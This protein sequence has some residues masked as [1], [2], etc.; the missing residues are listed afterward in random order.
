MITFATAGKSNS[1]GNRK[2]PHDLPD[3]LA[4]FGLNGFEVQC[5]RGINIS[6]E[7]YDFLSRQSDIS[8]SL[9]T[10]YFISISSVD[11]DTRVRSVDKILESARAAQRIGARRIVVHSGS[12]AKMSRG[13]ALSLALDTL[14]KAREALD[15]NG[16]EHIAICPETM[17]KINQLGTLEEVLELC[18][19]DPRMIPC[20][21]FG[22]LNARSHGGIKGR[23]DYAA[24]FDKIKHTLGD[25]ILQ[26]LHIHFSKI[27][28]TKGGTP[29][30]PTG[31]E[32]KHLTFADNTFGPDYEPLLD[33]I[34][35]R[36][37][38]PFIVCESDGTQAEDCAKMAEY[39]RKRT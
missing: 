38:E 3:Y 8:L 17:G 29:D 21:D 12:C 11:G 26:N 18:A 10:P 35:A 36:R 9:H 16:L 22:H 2:Y 23:N 15:S 31:G 32:K 1:F 28:Y 5:G 25:K 7:A 19:F 4:E 24:I 14:K 30:K 33:E 13:D 20:V 39:C 27:E 37:L 6:G 34:I